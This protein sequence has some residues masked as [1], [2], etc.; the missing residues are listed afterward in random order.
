VAHF[1]YFHFSQLNNHYQL[2][3]NQLPRM[4]NPNGITDSNI[5]ME[6]LQ[7]A[8]NNE[9]AELSAV[10]SIGKIFRTKVCSLMFGGGGEDDKQIKQ[11]DEE[12]EEAPP[13]PSKDDDASSPTDTSTTSSVTLDKDATVDEKTDIPQD[14]GNDN[15]AQ[16]V[17]TL[18][19]FMQPS[20]TTTL[21][22][23]QSSPATT[24]KSIMILRG[25]KLV[26]NTTYPGNEG[27]DVLEQLSIS[28]NQLSI[29]CG[30]NDTGLSLELSDA[31]N[32]FLSRARPPRNEGLT[33]NRI[34]N[35]S[36]EETSELGGGNNDGTLVLYSGNN[37]NNN[38]NMND[39][40]NS[41]LGDNESFSLSGSGDTLVNLDTLKAQ[42]DNLVGKYDALLVKRDERISEEQTKVAFLTERNEILHEQ[43]IQALKKGEDTAHLL[44]EI[45]KNETSI[46][47]LFEMSE[48]FFKDIDFSQEKIIHSTKRIET[49]IFQLARQMEKNHDEVM[50]GQGALMDFQQQSFADL[51][52]KLDQVL[53]ENRDLTAKLLEKKSNP[54]NP[55]S[56]RR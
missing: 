37:N 2:G 33:P 4:S 52:E 45:E 36:K 42:Q 53:R 9:D 14:A 35:P 29:H 5:N 20:S 24:P 10:T 13:P 46:F 32:N 23:Q 25:R 15:N 16:F 22:K 40:V 7:L 27:K 56:G 18:P 12:D 47:R 50:A 3:I 31:E 19:F 51:F 6:K 21:I 1:L 11:D 54:F 8:D 34:S 30:N 48:Q 38:N 39:S 17:Q 41:S 26:S 55:F 44:A 49:A 28:T 43:V